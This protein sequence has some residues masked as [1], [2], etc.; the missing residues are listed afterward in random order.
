MTEQGKRA[1]R[2]GGNYYSLGVYFKQDLDKYLTAY[3]QKN[4]ENDLRYFIKPEDV[5]YFRTS[6][7]N[8]L[9]DF[10]EN[11][12]VHMFPNASDIEIIEL[13]DHLVSTLTDKEISKSYLSDELKITYRNKKGDVLSKTI[14]SKPKAEAL[15]LYIDLSE[16]MLIGINSKDSTHT[17]NITA[18]IGYSYEK[19]MFP[20]L[21][22][23][24]E[25]IFQDYRIKNP[26]AYSDGM[27][28]GCT[29]DKPTAALIGIYNPKISFTN[30]IDSQAVSNADIYFRVSYFKAEK[31]IDVR[32]Y[33]KIKH[34]LF[35]NDF[36]FSSFPF[37]FQT[38]NYSVD[39][40]SNSLNIYPVPV[41]GM[42]DFLRHMSKKNISEWKHDGA[43]Y[44]V[45]SVFREGYTQNNLTFMHRYERN[46]HYYLFKIMLPILIILFVSW[47]V[48][49]IHPTQIEA[50]FT[51][52]IVCLLSLIAYTFII[53]QD[54]PKLAYLTFMDYVV[55]VSYF[56]S[57]IPTV[58]TIYMHHFINSKV[59]TRSIE[60]AIN[61]DEKSRKYY[62]AAYAILIIL[63]LL[64]VLNA[65][66][67]VIKGLSFLSKNF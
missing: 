55:L 38:L 3:A 17:S 5:K 33:I 6:S 10:F 25:S 23:F 63:I 28:F 1:E 24:T 60:N 59:D 16:D 66:D 13:N 2:P 21:L 34:G 49:W 7:N 36:Q 57:V 50:R 42:P 54:I 11:K 61:F 45:S 64:S 19:N 30:L 27:G 53:D 4:K 37:D 9:V 26:G 44:V 14:T 22:S 52:S 15:F 43:D 67:N 56:F 20:E 18:S 32:K 48:F 35:K 51:V 8:I 62:L 65:S 47:A 29:Y 31:R 46:Y 40:D 39:I 12:L 41:T 58:Q